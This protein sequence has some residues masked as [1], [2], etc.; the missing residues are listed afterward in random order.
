M[1]RQ[2]KTLKEKKASD[3]RHVH[4]LSTSEPIKNGQY[5]LSD[6]SSSSYSFSIKKAANTLPSF[7]LNKE[8]FTTL[9]VSS[10]IA[11][12][13]LALFFLLINHIITLP[14]RSLQY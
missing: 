13:Q 3:L 8:L 10:G 12:L 6:F 9:T 2:R 4:T 5:S 7:S 1:G 11:I 14:I